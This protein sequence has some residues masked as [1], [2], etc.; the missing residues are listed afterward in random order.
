MITNNKERISGKICSSANDFLK[1]FSQ[2]NATRDRP[3]VLEELSFHYEPKEDD[4]SDEVLPY[5]AFRFEAEAVDGVAICVELFIMADLYTTVLVRNY[6]DSRVVVVTP[7]KKL[8]KSTLLKKDFFSELCEWI[9]VTV[10]QA[11][12]SRKP[13]ESDE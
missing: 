7:N 6:K 2:A 8:L 4:S 13:E 12:D 11:V 5:A 3:F 10:Q 9:A 1:H